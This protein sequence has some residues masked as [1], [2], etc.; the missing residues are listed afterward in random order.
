[1]VTGAPEVG[2]TL[3]ADAGTYRDAAGEPVQ[4]SLAYQW[5]RVTDA[6]D[7]PI[8]GATRATYRAASADLGYA[9]KVKV[10]ATRSGYPAQTTLSD[11][12]DP[13]VQGD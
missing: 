11:P 9:L 1:M 4:P 8:A 10:T 2:H 7:V 6:G 3:G 5:Y 12:T 13:V